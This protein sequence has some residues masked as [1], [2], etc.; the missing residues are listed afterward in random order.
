M[1]IKRFNEDIEDNGNK[2]MT[3]RV[4][5]LIEYLSQFDPETPVY[6]DKDGWDYDVTNAKNEVDVI[7]QRGL[8]DKYKDSL[9]INN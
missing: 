7:D 9:T 8:F 5:H 3:I 6:L 1:N 4:K 2:Q